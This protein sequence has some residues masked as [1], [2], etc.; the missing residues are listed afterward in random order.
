MSMRM[1]ETA[2]DWVASASLNDAGSVP[3]SRRGINGTNTSGDHHI[4]LGLHDDHHV[5]RAAALDLAG[6]NSLDTLCVP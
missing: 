3:A 4:D 6:G 5:I 2:L 1:V